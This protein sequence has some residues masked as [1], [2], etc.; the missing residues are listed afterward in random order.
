MRSWPSDNRLGHP[1]AV[2]VLL[3]AVI[4][5][6]YYPSFSSGTNS[7]DDPG[8]FAFF[9]NPPSLCSIL[10]P[11]TSYYFRPIIEL[12]Y[13]LDSRL[14]GLEPAVMHLE[15]ILLHMAN[16]V[17]VFFLARRIAG[18]YPKASPLVPL[19]ASLLFALNPLNV[20]A[21]AWIAGRTDPLAALFVLAACS[22]LLRWLDAARWQDAIVCICFFAAAVL[23]KETSSALAAAAVLFV[24]AW[25]GRATRQQRAYAVSAMV[26]SGILLLVLV[27]MYLRGMSSLGRFIGGSDRQV[28]RLIVDGLT[29]FGFYVKKLFVPLPLNFAITEVHPAY[30]FLG[31]GTILAL[32]WMLRRHRLAGLFFTSA[33]L[34]MLPAILIASRQVTWTPYA[35]RYLYLSSAFFSLG[36]CAAVMELRKKLQTVCVVVLIILLCGA[37]LSSMQR[38][39][40]WK[41]K[42]AFY[43]DAVAKSPGFGSVYNELGG[44]LLQHG[45]VD[46]AADAFATADRLNKRPSM[47]MLI[48]A[49]LMG[50]MIARGRPAEARGYFFELF[51]D[52]SEASADF[53]ELLY[54]ADS[55]RLTA[56]SESERA[57]LAGDVLETL[58]L[59][60]RKKP[61]PFWLYQ[62]GKMLL[63]MGDKSR[64][65]DFFRHSYTAAPVDA[66]YRSAAKTYYL[67]LE[68]GK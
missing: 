66:H 22:F 59:L 9:A 65:A 39:L 18:S 6:V 52:K 37:A 32:C 60:N 58:D 46:K 23:T 61:D 20:E 49:N 54:L 56:I 15:N 64:A 7:V 3:V 62:S 16:A 44:L 13:Y 47:K 4:L 28:F 68:A 57:V 41:D 53:L 12:S 42:L 5:A 34:L 36:V 67:R 45:E 14:W 10:L 63:I 1:L 27:S 33:S 25:P 19:L 50:S 8:I 17:L 48:K 11:G 2:P 24:L 43:Q 26:L 31:G 29:A 55:Q 21:V 38:T 51:K 30:S 40:L 35:E